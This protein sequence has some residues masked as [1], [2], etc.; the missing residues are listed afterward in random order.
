[1][2]ANIGL[3]LVVA[4]WSVLVG[5][6]Y[7]IWSIIEAGQ[8]EWAGTTGLAL[9]AVLAFFIAFYLWRSH[10][11]QR[12]ELPED[13]LDSDIDDG[14][15]E[16]GFFSPWSWWPPLLGIAAALGFLGMAVGVWISALGIGIFA[17]AIVG[18]VY[19]YYRGFHAR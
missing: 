18:W 16:V 5:T 17:I 9:T 10:R 13:S 1:M 8:I 3:L 6:T 11:S 14:D 19:E 2:R 15:P 4:G 7:V 12:G